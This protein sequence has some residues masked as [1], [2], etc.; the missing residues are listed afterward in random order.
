MKKRALLLS[1]GVNHDLDHPRYRNDIAA[2]FHLLTETHGYQESDIRMCVGSGAPLRL[3]G[4]AGERVVPVLAARWQHVK[5]ALEW[6]AE[7]GPED[8]AF[9]MVTDHGTQDGISLWGKNSYLTPSTVKTILDKSSAMKILV[10]GQCNSGVFGHHVPMNSIV[11][12]ACEPHEQSWPLRRPAP[13]VEPAY[14]EFLY[15]LAGALRGAYPDGLA[16]N[17]Y[18]PIPPPAQLTIGKAFEY[19]RSIDYWFI[20]EKEFPRMLDPYNLAHTVGL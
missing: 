16:L 20:Q 17:E 1:G 4:V 2:Y 11:C 8:R 5:E 15:H 14:D 13:G 19:A 12:C 18:D 3:T 6:L 9:V 10:Y 7:L